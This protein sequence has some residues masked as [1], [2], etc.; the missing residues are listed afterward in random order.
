MNLNGAHWHLLVN[1]F[2]IIGSLIATTVLG[3]GLFRRNESVWSLPKK[4]P[5]SMSRVRR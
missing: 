3:F 2:P 1:H 5:R 4:H